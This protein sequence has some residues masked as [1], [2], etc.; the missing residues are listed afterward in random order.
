MMIFIHFY[1]FKELIK[2]IL[3]YISFKLLVYPLT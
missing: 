3:I 1:L 2:K